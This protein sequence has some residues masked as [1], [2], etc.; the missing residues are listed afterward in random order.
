M[1]PA[2]N[3]ALLTP[4][5]PGARR[6]GFTLVELLITVV[7]LGVLAAIAVPSM[8]EFIARQRV[9][10]IAKELATDLRYLRAKSIEG[11]A[12]VRIKFGSNT[13]NTCYVLFALG[14]NELDCNCARTDGLASCGNAAGRGEEFKTVL[15][16]RARGVTV[17]A[18]PETLV[19]EGFNGLPLYR[20]ATQ[21][22]QT[23]QA[24]VS[25]ISTG[26]ALRVYTTA[27]DLIVPKLCSVGG[28]H[29]AFAT[30]TP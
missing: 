4:T 23:I 26:G 16:P 9:E 1:N 2:M 3:N 28:Q 25:G 24:V 7:I 17:A 27:D 21:S 19:L 13:E 6:H 5:L 29:G 11:K 8:R 15:I 12:T 14:P 22:F 30:C 18:T 20:T 10:S